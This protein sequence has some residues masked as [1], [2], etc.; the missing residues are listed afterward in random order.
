MVGLV[1]ELDELDDEV[2]VDEEL[3]LTETAGELVLSLAVVAAV[4]R[5][6]EDVVSPEDTER[7]SSVPS[8]RQIGNNDRKSG[9]QSTCSR[10]IHYIFYSLWRK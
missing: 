5:V 8:T 7:P 10:N 4:T 9:V 1:A 2:D 3:M 6:V